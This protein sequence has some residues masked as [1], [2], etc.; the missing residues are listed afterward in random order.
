MERVKV[1]LAKLTV[2]VVASTAVLTDADSTANAL[3]ATL[4]NNLDGDSE[5][6]QGLLAEMEKVG[7]EEDAK[8]QRSLKAK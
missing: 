8:L 7:V 3:T 1:P 2:N 6:I 4:T 5:I